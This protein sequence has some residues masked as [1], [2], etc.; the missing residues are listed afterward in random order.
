MVSL[1]RAS[2]YCRTSSAH[3]CEAQRP[4]PA[5][6]QIFR[7]QTAQVQVDKGRQG[8]EVR[9]EIPSAALRHQL[10]AADQ[11]LSEERCRSIHLSG[12]KQR[13]LQL[14]SDDSHY[15]RSV[16]VRIYL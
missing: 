15:A 3:Q 16:P 6:M 5:R 7:Q 2:N 12:F 9:R 1:S 13:C 14:M 4:G 11:S 10:C 8:A